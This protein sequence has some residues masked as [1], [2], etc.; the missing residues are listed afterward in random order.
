MCVL[1]CAY[2]KCIFVMCEFAFKFF[3]S[4]I[5]NK[6]VK[7]VFVQFAVGTY[8]YVR[9]CRFSDELLTRKK[10]VMM[11]K[12]CQ[13]S[14]SWT[15]ALAIRWSLFAIKAHRLGPRTNERC[16]EWQSMNKLEWK[17]TKT[18]KTTVAGI[19]WTVKVFR[20]KKMSVNKFLQNR[21][22]TTTQTMHTRSKF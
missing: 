10:K 11:E 22:T 1:P 9:V 21:Q 6:W 18:T 16:K 17:A 8:I 12:L 20:C 7:C 5:V 13:K 2:T 4:S 19:F 14:T 3:C 15:A